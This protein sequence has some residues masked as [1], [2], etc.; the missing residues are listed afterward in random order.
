[1]GDEV[2]RLTPRAAR[3]L[4]FTALTGAGTSSANA[5]YFS[6]AILDT[7]L[8]GLEGHGFYWLQFY[9]EHVRSGKVKGKAKP[10][11]KSISPVSFRVDAGSGF[12]HPAIEAGFA[13]LIPAAK[14][15]G[16]AGMAVHN[17]YNAATL[18]FHTGFLARHGLVAFGFTNSPPALAP[19]GGRKP[20]LGT[21]PMSFAVPG[22]KGRI[23]FLVDQ[24]S[25]AVAWTAVKRAAEAGRKI[26]LGW[27][28]D[29]NGVPTTDPAKGLAGSM[30]P[31]G[32]YKGFG[33]GLIVEVMCAAM[34]GSNLG[35]QMG[36]FSENDG[37][38][39]DNGQFFVAIDPRKFSG[40]QFDRQVKALMASITAQKGAR[41]P[42]ARREANQKRL[43]RE[44]LPIDR[45]L[46]DR[47][48]SFAK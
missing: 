23:A 43:K 24:S 41:L 26:P 34:T 25:S 22:R 7:E 9:C 27:A 17:S 39:V 1:M 40:G 6:D 28:L 8:S 44:G 4:I 10:K 33:Q 18:G 36:S 30:A 46:Y 38:S 37:K 48:K 42:N 35:T 31:S 14:R 2:L 12:A 19:V 47:L 3:S 32:G 13:K 16:I 11:V 15:L 45:A 21:N 5:G 29:R 20:L